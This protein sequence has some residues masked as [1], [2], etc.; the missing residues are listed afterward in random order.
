MTQIT[1]GLR[2]TAD[3]SAVVT[4]AKQTEAA[5]GRIGQAA[6]GAN[7]QQ[8]GA[9]AAAGQAAAQTARAAQVSAQAADRARGAFARMGE[10]ARESFRQVTAGLAPLPG[11]LAGVGQSALGAA[12]GLKAL[13]VLGAALGLGKM[14][15]DA[16]FVA[17]RFQKLELRLSGLIGTGQRLAETQAFLSETARRQAQPLEALIDSYSKLLP[18]QQSGLLTTGQA[19]AILTGF[20][21]VAAATGATTAQLGQS[22]FGLA[23]GL[24]AG[25]LRAEELNQVT[26]PVPGL[27]QKL[28]QAAGLTAGGFRKLVVE[29]KVTS[30]MFRDILIKALQGYSGAAEKTADTLSASIVR[31]KNALNDLAVVAGGPVAKILGFVIGKTADLIQPEIP[32]RARELEAE[33][34]RLRA[35]IDRQSPGATDAIRRNLVQSSR[36]RL[37]VVEAE[38]A[39]MS[40]MRRRLGQADGLNQ[41]INSRDQTGNRASEALKSVTAN[42]EAREKLA[43]AEKDLQDA[44]AAGLDVNGRYAAA[45]GN[46]RFQLDS[47]K[48]PVADQLKGLRD[49]TRLLGEAG[50]GRAR[51]EA[52]LKAEQAAI[53][54]G[55]PLSAE[56]RGAVL[57]SAEARYRKAQA[58]EDE[59]EALKLL[60]AAAKAELA[61][62]VDAERARKQAIVDRDTALR[63]RTKSVSEDLLGLRERNAV[64]EGDG[65]TVYDIGIERARRWKEETLKGLDQAADGYQDFADKVQEVFE[66]QVA[67]AFEDSQEVSGDW[68]DGLRRG[69][70]DLK[71]T[72]DDWGGFTADTVRAA[73]QTGEEAFIRFV[74]TGKAQIGDLGDFILETFA[75][76]IYR[77]TVG[78]AIEGIVDEVL[79]ILGGGDTP[80]APMPKP[81]PEDNIFAGVFHAGGRVGGPAPQRLVPAHVFEG[82][83][84]MHAGGVVGLAAD[85]R[86][87]IA[88]VGETVSTPEQMAARGGT[89]VQI[90]DQRRSG[91][92]VETEESTGPDGMRMIR[93]VIRDEVGQDLRTNGPIARSMQGQFG[94]R[95]AATVRG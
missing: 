88:R 48:D 71:R 6:A 60:D 30:E 1:L 92:A 70:R 4:T 66:G 91:A 39:E 67:Q 23:Q 20:N 17:D 55:I 85:E 46:V 62:M 43:K 12:G 57:A 35:D 25:T 38:L 10:G 63:E 95:R 84:R 29:G 65:A 82:A 79:E 42:A 37:A 61:N 26:E 40:E 72:V 51:Q 28:D 3:G 19:R 8:A 18:L 94:A 31:L 34:T 2:I 93:V 81:A 7:Q 74:K 53:S 24:S 90:I 14:A 76:V 87:I 64:R 47:L 73:F 32:D 5:I 86:P 27:L 9:A 50:I 45:L 83:R 15:I 11:Q 59:A 75:R 13:T 49:E 16:A 54:R 58:I 44:I 36:E 80:P 78:R 22:L 33:R 69:F 56:E 52:L 68:V 21:D 77:R 89:V 41:T